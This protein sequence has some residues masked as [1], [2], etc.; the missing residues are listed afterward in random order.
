MR[1]VTAILFTSIENLKYY[2]TKACFFPV[3]VNLTIAFSNFLIFHSVG[4][5]PDFIC[6]RK[7]LT[8]CQYNIP[9][10]NYKE[11]EIVRDSTVG[12]GIDGATVFTIEQVGV[13][14]DSTEVD[15]QKKQL[16]GQRE[17]IL[18]GVFKHW[19]HALI[20]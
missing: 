18:V 17:K 13:G 10:S 4:Q 8:A 2:I 1:H 3:I 5:R 20:Y 11:P 9:L 19:S 14:S 16:I 12:D 6:K 15:V 7:K